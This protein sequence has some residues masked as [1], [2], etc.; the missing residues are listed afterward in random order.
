MCSANK[1]FAELAGYIAPKRKAVDHSLAAEYVAA[2]DRHQGRVRQPGW[3]G[4]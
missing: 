1:M 2:G 4:D 3:K